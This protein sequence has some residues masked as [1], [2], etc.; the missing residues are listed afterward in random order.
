MKCFYMKYSNEKN[1]QIIVSLLKQHGVRKVIASPGSANMAI[2]VTLQNDPFFEIYSS[3]DERS[4]AYMACGLAETSGETVAITCT[5]ATASRNY[6]PGLTEA[7][8]RKLPVVAITAFRGG[9]DMIGQLVPQNIDRTQI[10]HDVALI[11]VDVPVVKD[12]EDALYANRLV[13]QALLETKR[14]GGGPVHI[15]VAALYGNTFFD[16]DVP[17][18][19]CIHR[20]YAHDDFPA[21]KPDVKVA[22]FCGAITRFTA[23]EQQ[24]LSDF[25]KSHN[26]VVLCDHS[27]NYCGE[28]KVLSSLVSEN[29]TN[30]DLY[31]DLIIHIGEVSGDYPTM[32]V[33]QSSGAEVWRVS[34]DGEIRD[35]FG[36]LTNVFECSLSDFFGQYDSSLSSTHDYY[37]AWARRRKELV[38]WM[39]EFPYSHRWIAQKTSLLIPDNSILHFAILNSLRTWNCF[40][41]PEHVRCFCNTGGFGIDGAISTMLGSALADPGKLNILVTGDLAFFYD[42]NALGNRHVLNNVRILLINNGTGGEFHMPYSSG[43]ALGDTIDPYVAATGHYQWKSYDEYAVKPSSSPAGQWAESLG[44]TYIAAHS[45]SDFEQ[46]ISDFLDTN[47]KTPI[48]MECFTFIDDDALAAKMIGDLDP[49]QRKKQEI[50]ATVKKMLPKGVLETIKHI[51]K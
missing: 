36:R 14:H 20:Y 32:G 51:K 2:V 12:E 41:L 25:I 49:T 6:L 5:G 17:K 18:S 33:L 42:M 8:Y 1:S 15:N 45:K 9:A 43:S 19:R 37:N 4:A 26:S 44:F 39:P 40:E 16:G 28:G 50:R 13:N 23:K 47:S 11:S 35:Y 10:Q 34:E 46:S 48:L 38:S 21:I 31:P 27:V 29:A 3:V 24:T 30:P 7:Y 22:V